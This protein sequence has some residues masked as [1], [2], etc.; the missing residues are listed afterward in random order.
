MCLYP[1]SVNFTICD[2]LSTKQY[3]HFSDRNRKKSPDEWE[4]KSN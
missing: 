3:G 4:G 1:N 2:P